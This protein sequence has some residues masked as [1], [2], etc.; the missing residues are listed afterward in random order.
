MS[1]PRIT[2]IGSKQSY[3]SH[4]RDE[5]VSILQSGRTLA[6]TGT[7]S[8]ARQEW[9][10]DAATGRLSA[11]P[12]ADHDSLLM[13][14]E[15]LFS[16]NPTLTE[17]VLEGHAD[18]RM[19][20]LERGTAQQDVQGVVHIPA[21][22]F[23]QLDT[24]WLTPEPAQAPPSPKPSQSTAGKQALQHPHRPEKRH[25]TLYRRYIPWLGQTLSLRSLQRSQDLVDFHRWMHHPQVSEFWQQADSLEVL[26][27]YLREL[28]AD[29]HCQP[30]IGCF[31][32]VPFA[33][34]E[35][36]WAKEDRLSAHYDAEDYDRGWHLLVGEDSYRG[37]PWFSAWFPSLQHYLFLDDPRTQRI[38][39][40]PRHDNHRLIRHAHRTG[41]NT[42]KTF[43]FPHKRAQLLLLSR[44]RFFQDNR[45]QPAPARGEPTG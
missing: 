43:D 23:W 28:E 16:W 1:P 39:A 37:R 18:L 21:A 40:E 29:P 27:S 36:Y 33:Y 30:V 4:W 32:N 45:I 14:L 8:H 15:A 6:L 38:V 12:Q 35:L 19:S 11:C 26:D 7:D 41:F 5:P 13:V 17:I 9:Y 22:R 20:L 3:I 34:F 31:D 2:P 25:G 24:L 42:L 10:W 44:E